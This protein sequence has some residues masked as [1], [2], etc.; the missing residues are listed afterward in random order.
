[1]EQAAKK[2][3]PKKREPKKKQRE[4]IAGFSRFLHAMNLMLEAAS[5]QSK[6]NLTRHETLLLSIFRNGIIS[7]EKFE[8]E[9]RK[10]LVV[11]PQNG[12]PEDALTGAFDGLVKKKLIKPVKDSVEITKAGSVELKR[13]SDQVDKVYDQLIDNLHGKDRKGLRDLMKKMGVS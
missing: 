1:M 8:R 5:L 13:I 6:H 7:R 9:F 4:T 10:L 12:S 2:K 3:T 11:Q